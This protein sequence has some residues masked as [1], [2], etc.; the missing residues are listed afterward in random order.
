MSPDVKEVVSKLRSGNESAKEL[1]SC[2]HSS[3]DC[4]HGDNASQGN[5]PWAS[6]TKKVELSDGLTKDTPRQETAAG[7]GDSARDPSDADVQDATV[8]YA[9]KATQ[10][11]NQTT[12]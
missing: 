12:C 11:S 3:S 9:T 4:P 6:D 1:Q 5:I 8:P 10:H 2:D 7:K